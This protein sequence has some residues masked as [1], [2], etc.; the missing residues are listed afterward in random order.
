M[1]EFQAELAA[2]LPY[3]RVRRHFG[4]IWSAV[5][6]SFFA[7]CQFFVRLFAVTEVAIERGEPVILIA[8][9]VRAFNVLKR[10]ITNQDDLDVSLFPVS[11]V[12]NRHSLCSSAVRA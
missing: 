6:I 3:G 1:S 10:D 7:E 9:P 4:V 12:L 11:V 5:Q 2:S 8:I